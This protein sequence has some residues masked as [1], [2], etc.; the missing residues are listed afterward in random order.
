[1]DSE[2]EIL[3]TEIHKTS[4][5]KKVIDSDLVEDQLEI[6]DLQ[7]YENKIFENKIMV[8]K[9]KLQKKRTKSFKILFP[10]KENDGVNVCGLAIKMVHKRCHDD[11]KYMKGG[12]KT[13]LFK[14]LR[15]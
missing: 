7:K 3:K 9:Q 4:Q 14:F 11:L 10:V 8:I 2:I 13:C 5:N 12:P 1:M 15:H 6:D